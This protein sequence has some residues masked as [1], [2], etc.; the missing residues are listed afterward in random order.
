MACILKHFAETTI[1]I[2]HYHL[3][4]GTTFYDIHVAVGKVNWTVQHRFK[5]FDELNEK[6]VTGHSISSDLMPPKKVL[7]NR[8]PEFLVQRQKLLEIYLQKVLIFF[9]YT[10]CREFVEFLDFNKYDIIY[11]LQDISNNFYQQGETILAAS[12]VH[13]FTTLELYSITERLK[14]PCPSSDSVRKNFDFSHVLDFCS[15]L[16]SLVVRPR[17]GQQQSEA[18]PKIELN[19]SIGTSNIIPGNLKF[20]L[21]AFR[22]LKSFKMYGIRPEN[23]YD[24]GILRQ[25]ISHLSVHSTSTTQINQIL[26]C[27]CIH[28]AD[29]IDTTKSWT[30]LKSAN[31]SSNCIQSIDPSIKLLPKLKTLILDRNHITTISNLSQLPYLSSLSLCE[32]FITECIDCHLELGNLKTLKLSQ[33]RL[34]SLSGFRK[35]Y[36]LVTLD[37]SCNLIADIEEINHVAGLPCLEELILTANPVAG[38]VDYRQRVLSRFGDRC[39]ELFLDNEKAEGTEIDMALVLAALRQSEAK[40]PLLQTSFVTER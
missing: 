40:P 4:D 3:V 12:K 6:L 9:R 23:I 33:N 28:K 25:T 13:E 15:Q 10:M 38:I 7:G 29:S 1:K 18:I 34:T 27:D 2:P 36:S 21:N 14:L 37:V 19:T 39:T 22:S 35:M 11:L 31:F 8:N 16:Q 5:E 24:A 30:E 32:N 20:D 26:L 17:K